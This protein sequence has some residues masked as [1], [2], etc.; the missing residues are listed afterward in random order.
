M[1]HVLNTQQTLE[2]TRD[3]T[4]FFNNCKQ[5]LKS[6]QDGILRYNDYSKYPST[7]KYAFSSVL[8]S[9]MDT[10]W[11]LLYDYLLQ[12]NSLYVIILE[13]EV[14]YVSR[15]FVVHGYCQL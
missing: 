6:I 9:E 3:M 12:I 4:A 14:F 5:K 10:E 11:D 7:I 2:S 15:M 13:S 8:Q 1:S